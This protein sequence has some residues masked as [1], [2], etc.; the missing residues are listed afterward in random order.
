MA[1][2]VISLNYDIMVA[3]WQIEPLDAV[4]IYIYGPLDTLFY[5]NTVEK[6]KE[7]Q[8]LSLVEEVGDNTGYL[9]WNGEK[10]YFIRYGADT[11]TMTT[12]SIIPYRLLL[13]DADKLKWKFLFIGMMAVLFAV[14]ASAYLSGKLCTN[15]HKLTESMR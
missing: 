13:Q 3:T 2:V 10:Q 12:I 11:E 8:L 7:A 9:K 6:G 4:N 1:A 15:L 14:A 5:T